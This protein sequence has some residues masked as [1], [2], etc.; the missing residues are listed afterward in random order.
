MKQ[1]N[2]YIS[3]EQSR[4]FNSIEKALYRSLLNLSME[5]D[6]FKLREDGTIFDSVSNKTINHTDHA[7][8][9]AHSIALWNIDQFIVDIVDLAFGTESFDYK[10]DL[11]PC[12]THIMWKDISETLKKDLSFGKPKRG[13][14]FSDD[15]SNFIKHL[16]VTLDSQCL[17]RLA[18][19][20]IKDSGYN[21]NIVKGNGWDSEVNLFYE[22]G[23]DCY[24]FLSDS[25]ESE[26]L[27]WYKKVFDSTK[28]ESKVIEEILNG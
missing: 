3:N 4:K 5:I 26:C 1:K 27:G 6:R 14:I 20:R 7:F 15:L 8:R 24:K 2:I 16:L 11:V 22:M 13:R 21:I 25:S 9:E 10:G 18:V 28:T 23:F 17:A 19:G 12:S